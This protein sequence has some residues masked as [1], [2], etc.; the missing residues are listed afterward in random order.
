MRFSKSDN[1]IGRSELF[2]NWP[3]IDHWR[4]K[5]WKRMTVLCTYKFGMRVIEISYLPLMAARVAARGW[6]SRWRLLFKVYIGYTINYYQPC[7][8][9]QPAC[10]STLP[11]I[12]TLEE[13]APQKLHF[14][15]PQPSQDQV[16]HDPLLLI[17]VKHYFTFGPGE[18]HGIQVAANYHPSI[19]SSIFY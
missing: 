9:L 16:F 5:W 7:A 2:F 17:A 15:P 19:L 3:W 14:F 13:A 18:R 4:Y 10:L 12:A 6:E 1:L 8:C 11:C